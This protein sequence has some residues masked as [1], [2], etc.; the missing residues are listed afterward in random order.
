MKSR[1][2]DE[3]RI[4]EKRGEG[5]LAKYIPWIFI[6]EISSS[7]VSWRIL[8]E[9]AGRIHHLLSTLEKNVFLYL[10]NHPDVIDIREQF[11]LPLRQTLLIAE[12]HKV[13]HG[14]FRGETK[15]MTTDFLVDLKDRQ[16]AIS[17]KPFSKITKRFLEKFQV[18]KTYWASKGVRLICCTEREIENLK[19][20]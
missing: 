1:T 7:G 2:K 6:H 16:V 14:Q 8:G 20:V 11:P 17:V 12:D 4:K 5:L 13:R 19:F 3:T 18:E 15:I 10:D 9:K